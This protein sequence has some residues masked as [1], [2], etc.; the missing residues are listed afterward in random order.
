MFHL[1]ELEGNAWEMPA[2]HPVFAIISCAG[3]TK[4]NTER[5]TSGSA[6]P[7]TLIST[8]EKQVQIYPSTLSQPHKIFCSLFL[9]FFKTHINN[10]YIVKPPHL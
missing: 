2:F 3:F 4:T 8:G 9:S 6:L 1:T 10:K 5:Q 7:D